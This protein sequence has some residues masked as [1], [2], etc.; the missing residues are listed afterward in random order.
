MFWVG[1]MLNGAAGGTYGANG[2]WQ[3]NR[4]DTPYGPSPHGRSWG[5][6]PWDEAMNRPSS[7]QVGMAKRFFARYPWQR[8]EPKPEMVGWADDQSPKSDIRP[9][10]LGVGI[11]LRIVYVPRPRPVAVRQLAPMADY[12]V[13]LFD[14]ITAGQSALGK[15]HTNGEGAW[16]SPVPERKQDWVLVL[17]R[18]GDSVRKP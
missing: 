17:E 1:L 7:A 6:T 11:D 5:S 4:R 15:A 2:I 10:A 3:V 9:L 14:P 8:L 12:R 18:Q 16:Q 13:S